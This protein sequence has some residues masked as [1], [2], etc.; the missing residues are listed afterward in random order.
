MI[1]LVVLEP[2]PYFV[3]EPKP[4]HAVREFFVRD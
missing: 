4:K 1:E 2:K 3:L